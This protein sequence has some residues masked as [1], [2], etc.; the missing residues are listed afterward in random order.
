VADAKRREG[1]GDVKSDKSFG[2]TSKE[3]RKSFANPLAEELAG[4]DTPYFLDELYNAASFEDIETGIEDR[5]ETNYPVTRFSL[6]PV[7]SFTSPPQPM[8]ANPPL[9]TVSKVLEMP[10]RKPYFPTL[11]DVPD[12]LPKPKET[13]PLTANTPQ[14]NVRQLPQQLYEKDQPQ[15]SQLRPHLSNHPEHILHSA[16]PTEGEAF[17]SVPLMKVMQKDR[18]MEKVPKQT[19]TPEFDVPTIHTLQKNG[20][21]S[22]YHRDDTDLRLTMDYEL[23]RLRARRTLLRG[24]WKKAENLNS[25]SKGKLS[26]RSLRLF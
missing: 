15:I 17:H 10:N 9:P 13:A 16:P 4:E 21:H 20:W 14:P 3:A 12:D 1:S 19:G 18:S 25:I 6:E 8:E 7:I 26:I 5:M 24:K 11:P 22:S 23:E 2:D